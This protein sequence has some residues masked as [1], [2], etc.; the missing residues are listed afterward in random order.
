VIVDQR[1]ERLLADVHAPIRQEVAVKLA[2]EFVAV[3]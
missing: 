1:D 3:V 2:T